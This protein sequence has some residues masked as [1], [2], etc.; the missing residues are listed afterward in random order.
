MSWS[1]IIVAKGMW[2]V[3]EKCLNSL[4]E[5]VNDYL[6][7]VYVDNDTPKTEDSWERVQDWKA[8]HPSILRHCHLYKFD[9]FTSLADCWNF[10]INEVSVGSKILLCNN[11]IVFHAP[12]WLEQFNEGLNQEGVGA[13]GLVGMSWRHTP[14]IQGC[15]LG[16]TTK[17]FY[18]VGDFDNQFQFTCEDVDWCRRMQ[19]LGLGIKSYENLREQG[20]VSHGEG[21]TRNYYK[22][23]IKEMQRLAHISRVN[24]C[25]KWT[26][27][28]ISIHD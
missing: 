26:Y 21:T 5:T 9:S 16:F 8:K 14:F 7:I 20:I 2:S 1:V 15:L 28:D 12:G 10:A 17:T 4:L 24:Y 13:V 11:D 19:N 25:Y 23:S 3:T 18:Q 6:Q 27:P 22:D